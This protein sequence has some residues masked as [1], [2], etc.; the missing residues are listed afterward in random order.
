MVVL[1]SWTT[2]VNQRNTQTANL[3]KSLKDLFN[4]LIEL[5]NKHQCL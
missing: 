2:S 1:W 3:I 5:I 4:L